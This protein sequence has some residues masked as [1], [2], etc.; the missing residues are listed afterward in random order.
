M[1]CLNIATVRDRWKCIPSVVGAV[2]RLE[3]GT[4]KTL[5]RTFIKIFL[6]YELSLF[7]FRQQNFQNLKR[8]IILYI[9]HYLSLTEN[10]FP[11]FFLNYFDKH[12]WTT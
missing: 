7:K 12:L 11:K 5:G 2:P 8:C 6:S 4:S 10:L 9:I 3:V 1:T